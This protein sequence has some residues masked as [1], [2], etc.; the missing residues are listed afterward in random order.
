[1]KKSDELI[2]LADEIG[3]KMDKKFIKEK[4]SIGEVKIIRALLIVLMSSDQFITYD[5]STILAKELNND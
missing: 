5:I 1:M 3:K 2:D 4:L